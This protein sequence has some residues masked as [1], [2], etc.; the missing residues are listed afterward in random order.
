MH[1]RWNCRPPKVTVTLGLTNGFEGVFSYKFIW[2][3]EYKHIWNIIFN[4]AMKGYKGFNASFFSFD[5]VDD[6]M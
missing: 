1:F 2:I 5:W 6:K 3:Y 4:F